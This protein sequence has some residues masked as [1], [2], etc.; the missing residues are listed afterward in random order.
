M[1][2][3]KHNKTKATLYMRVQIRA[4]PLAV[5]GHA[6]V[7]ITRCGV[8][9]PSKQIDGTARFDTWLPNGTRKREGH[10]GQGW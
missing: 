1:T 7:R 8:E 2:R 3:P 9:M 6:K 5:V 4:Q 10:V